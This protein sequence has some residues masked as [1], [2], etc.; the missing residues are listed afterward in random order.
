[1]R[2][3]ISK[4][5]VHADP[6]ARLCHALTAFLQRL[7]RLVA[8]VVTIAAFA[9]VLLVVALRQGPLVVPGLAQMAEESVGPETG[10]TLSIGA[11]R[12][13]LNDR[14][15]LPSLVFEDVGIS[16]FAGTEILSI[17]KI[18]ALFSTKSLIRGRLAPVALIVRGAEARLI[19][20]ED[21]R[22]SLSMAMADTVAGAPEL[23]A[24][25]PETPESPE[26]PGAPQAPEAP[27]ARG[28]TEA[29]GSTETA[30]AL[31]V[32]D[33]EA[34]V[35][36]RLIEGLSGARPLPTAL[37][38]LRRIDIQDTRMTLVSEATGRAIAG[39]DVSLRLTRRNGGLTGRLEAPL[40]LG[41]GQRVVLV[42]TG[43]R[44]RDSE[45]TAI[46]LSF[47][48]MPL[49]TLANDVPEL[50]LL[51]AIEAPVSGNLSATLT[52]TGDLTHVRGDLQ[53]RKGRLVLDD[54]RLAIDRLETQFRFEPDTG[55]MALETASLFGP[56]VSA[57]LS[58][59]GR[60]ARDAAGVPTRIE[61]DLALS[62]GLISLPDTLSSSA[63]VDR[64]SA[65]VSADFEAG[66]I[67]IAALTLERGALVVRGDGRLTLH[68]DGLRGA[69]RIGAENVSVTDLKALW[70]DG[71][72]GNA[73]PWVR[74][75]ILEGEIPSLIAHVGLA[76]GDATLAMDFE[77]RDL[78]AEPLKGM[79]P[80][81]GGS[82]SATLTANDLVLA[83]TTGTVSPSPNLTVDL[84][85]SS[86]RLFDFG[87]PVTPADIALRARGPVDGVLG[88][89]DRPPL[90]LVT[91]LGLPLGPVDGQ[92]ELTARLQFPL[93]KALRLAEIDVDVESR[94]AGVALDLA[95]P[96]MPAV[97]VSAPTLEINADAEALA[98]AGPI[99][100]AGSALAVRWQERY[101]A[102]PGRS[103]ILSGPMALETLEQLGVLPPGLDGGPAAVEM[104]IEQA[105]GGAP[106]LSV[107]ADL[108][109]TRIVPPTLAWQKEA[110]RPATLR[111]SVELGET[112]L[113]RNAVVTGS[114]LD[115]AG[116]GLIGQDG[117]M[118]LAIDRLRVGTLVDLGGNV[119]LDQ[120]RRDLRL[121]GRHLDI[122]ILRQAEETGTSA[123]D[124]L[125]G[126]SLDLSV[127]T[128][129]LTP[130]LQINGASGRLDRPENGTLS[131]RFSGLLNGEAPVEGSISLPPRGVGAGAFMMQSNDAGS[132]LRAADLAAEAR[133]GSLRLDAV[134][135]GGRLTALN[136]TATIRDIKL[137]ENSTFER[138]V[139]DGDLDREIEVE[140]LGFDQVEIPFRYRDGTIA[141]D[142]AI[143]VGS[144]LA[145]RLSGSISQAS[146]ALDMRGVASPA[147]AVSGF[148]D[149]IP[150]LGRILTGRRGEG[151]L[152]LTFSV[153]GSLDD[154]TIRVNPLSILVP[155]ILRD[156]FSAGSRGELDAD[157]DADDGAAPVAGTTGS[158]L[159]P[160]ERV[161]IIDMGQDR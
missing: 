55:V 139:R 82:G 109:D 66:R 86:M 60:I 125:P 157:A 39:E 91:K 33:E 103:L 34:A 78:V 11:A 106:L 56:T 31:G 10:V 40:L 47:G 1:M 67:D 65:V 26:A 61:A 41:D 105:G 145:V 133:G 8:S 77:Y 108:T 98:L 75:H 29:P 100:A 80:I 89:I 17:P 123:D 16:D 24:P 64:G 160:S 114:G 83:M 15:G 93:L 42:A 158:R 50:A 137:T 58:G 95:L 92:A 150:V 59:T 115:I 7:L 52:A 5:H 90:R 146:Q 35:I 85:G 129:A 99:T 149:S 153:T 13:G 68:D 48:P 32:D 27:Q 19:R 128:L 49:A 74:E 62:S 87:S 46:T 142:N 37:E 110:G 36:R 127:E 6:L 53:A 23:A 124:A 38:K 20:A 116:R 97:A 18:G 113:L 76:P 71:V 126:F 63:I 131:G 72:G 159:R 118:N 143:A 138:I 154:P 14:T 79:P 117:A 147:Y 70:P 111:A 161:D 21:G 134:L 69:L 54:H 30:D 141:I 2:A 43:M 25:V 156:L 45:D 144:K 81:V 122:A 73:R 104:R 155:G 148:L 101:G 130:E 4:R 119:L 88:V 28:A 140:G 151:I 57:E 121:T 132:F 102:D 12:L 44:R 3:S 22:V 135:P 94:V 96:G 107:D 152:G 112:I 120:G 9:L 136:G 84:A 51:A